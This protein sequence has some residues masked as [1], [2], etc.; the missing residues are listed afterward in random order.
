MIEFLQS[1]IRAFW[2]L[3]L[4]IP[5]PWR[6]LI[7]LLLFMLVFPWFVWRAFPWLFFIF[8]HL[9]L[10]CGKAL[11]Y[12]LLSIEYFV[13]QYIR[14]QGSQPPIFIYTFGDLLSDIVRTFDEVTQ[15][16]KKILDYALKKQWLLHRGWFVISAIVF[17]LTWYFRPVFGE[18]TIA[19]FIDRSVMSWY[20]IEGWGLYSRRSLSSALSSPA[21]TKFVQAYYLAINE[22]QYPE[23]WNCLSPKFQSKNSN[24]SGGF[25]SYVNWWETVEQVNVNEIILEQ[26]DSNSARVKITLRHLMK[27]NQSLSQPESVRLSLVRDAKTNKWMINSSKPLS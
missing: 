12:V 7:V 10:I 17:T 11:A 27:K 8:S 18:N 3:L 16:S 23:A 25:I 5:I 9:V 24:L 1:I 13:T 4:I 2:E 19:Q 15:K 21:P 22:R 6:L 20:S 26:Q 14:Q